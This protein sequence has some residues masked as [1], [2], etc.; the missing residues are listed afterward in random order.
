MAIYID[1]LGG[2]APIDQAAV[3]EYVDQQVQDL[4]SGAPAALNTIRELSEA[5]NNDPE[6]AASLLAGLANKLNLTGGTVTGP[7]TLPGSPTQPLQAAT[8]SYVDTSIANMPPPVTSLS[9]LTDVSVSSAVTGQVLAFNGTNWYPANAGTGGGGGSG[10]GT[11]ITG[12]TVNS[13]GELIVTLSTGATINAGVVIGEQ[14]PQGPAGPQGAPGAMGPQGLQ[15]PA[16]LTGPTGATGAQG[17]AGAIGPQGLQGP[18]GAPGAT[19]V[20][21]PQGPAG[22]TG[23]TGAQGPAGAVGPRGLTGLQGPQGLTG[24]AGTDGVSVTSAVVNANGNLILTLSN[25]STIN[26]GSSVGPA[27]PQG[28][29][30]VKGDTGATGPQGLQGVKGD[31]GDAGADSTVPGPQGLQGPAGAQGP[32]GVKGDTGDQGLQGPA[33]ISYSLNGIADEVQV[34]GIS[35][36]TQP[37]FDLEV[38]LANRA[39]KLTTPRNIALS[40]KV[41]GLTTFDGSGNVTML[42]AL[43]GVTTN[44]VAEGANQY[45]TAARARS[46]LSAGTGIS[47]NSTTG[48]VSLNANTDQVPEGANNLYYTNNRFDNRLA[49]SNLMALADVANVTPTTGQALI[50]NGN[51]WTPGT[52]T[53]TGGTGGGSGVYKASVQVD[54]DASGNLSNISVLTGGI[55]AVIATATSTV[56]T[57]TF[58]FIGSTVAPLGVQVYGYQRT[59][60]VYVSRAL[61]SDFPA[62]TILGGGTSG[63]PTAFSAFDAANNTMTLGLTRAATGATAGVGQTTH[64]VIQFL[65]STD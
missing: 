64:C 56:A 45:F 48:V 14:G 16:G 49:Q 37:G 40:G 65:L 9:N 6:F 20:A 43:S 27:G 47:Y 44:D 11:S 58:T 12:V 25:G 8:K 3:K 22:S 55:S 19:G 21:G 50:W 10:D 28:I 57:V 13:I 53:G 34:Y 15:G 59:S 54:Y 17:P 26:A 30:G 42:T 60:N 7:I 63:S 29:Q 51:T 39:N 24:P 61:A 62:R 4:V 46:A 35:T 33:G 38:D 18:A 2:D 23:A 1:D 31:K 52:V 5:L 32:Q 36:T 41:T